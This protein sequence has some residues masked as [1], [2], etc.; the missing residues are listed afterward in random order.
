MSFRFVGLSGRSGSRV[1]LGDADFAE[2]SFNLTLISFFGSYAE[3][4]NVEI[5]KC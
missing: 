4:Q 1:N 2:Y 3:E 5:S